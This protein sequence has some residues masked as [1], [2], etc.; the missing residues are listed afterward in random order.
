MATGT[1]RCQVTSA[2]ASTV[3]HSARTDPTERS[4]PPA[5]STSVM[6]T[7][8]TVSDGIWLASVVNVMRLK[9]WSLRALNKTRSATRTAARPRCSL[10]RGTFI[11]DQ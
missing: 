3:E 10:Y 2:C 1:G 4:M 9:K 6:P 7:A 11:G 5:I 8:I